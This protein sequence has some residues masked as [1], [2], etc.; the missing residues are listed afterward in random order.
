MI[1]T[2]IRSNDTVEYDLNDFISSTHFKI[3]AKNSELKI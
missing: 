1:Y 2:I 3:A